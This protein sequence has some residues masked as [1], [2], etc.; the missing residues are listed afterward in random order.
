MI[1]V[2]KITEIRKL[3]IRTCKELQE[4]L[5]L[6]LSLDGPNFYNHVMASYSIVSIRAPEIFMKVMTYSKT[7]TIH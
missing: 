5:M 6:F 4:I 3:E 2:E 7:S 1:S